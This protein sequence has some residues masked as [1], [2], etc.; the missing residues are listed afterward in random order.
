MRFSVFPALLLLTTVLGAA[1]T[2]K[3]VLARMDKDAATFHQITAKIVKTEYTAVLDDSSVESGQMWLRRHGREVAMRVEIAQP[4]G[5]SIGVTA[6]T[7]EVY[8]PKMNTVQIY[9]LGKAGALVDQFLVLGFGSS[10]KELERNYTVT[11]AGEE[12]VGGQTTSHL[13]LTPKSAKVLEQIKKVE[14]WIPQN[15][16]YPVQQR[17]VEPGGNYYLFTY[18]DVRLNPDLP[19]SAFA[20]NLPP[21]VHEEYPQRT[22]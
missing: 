17:V 15:A 11:M 16:G 20:L 6:A 18:S 9:D 8:Y 1:D 22:Q 19:G 21:N 13:V 4:Q 12:T 5:R 3:A 7:A 14:L 2:V 10:G